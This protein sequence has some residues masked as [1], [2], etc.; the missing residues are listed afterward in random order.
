MNLTDE[1][2]DLLRAVVALYDAG[3]TSQVIVNRPQQRLF[4]DYSG[5][6]PPVPIS[7]DDS[8]FKQL[9]HERLVTLH[10]YSGGDHREQC[11]ACWKAKKTEKS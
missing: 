8:D 4:A 3:D 10:R 5:G 1:H 6:H 11:C 9:E 2:Y 7:A